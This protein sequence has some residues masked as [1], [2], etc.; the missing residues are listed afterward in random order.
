[1]KKILVAT[2]LLASLA[3]AQRNRRDWLDWRVTDQETVQRSYSV[4][5]ASN[6]GASAKLAVDNVSGFVHVT[7]YSGT[8]VQ[9]SVHK[10]IGAD[11]SSAMEDAKREV[12]LDMSQQGDSVR[13]YVDGPFR[14]H[15]G[16]NYRGDGYYGYRV[17]YDFEIQVPTATELNLKTINYG[18]IV[19]K[20]TQGDFTIGGLNG[21]IE[22]EDVAGAG[23]V[24]TLNGPV[25]VT[26]TRNPTKDTEFRTLNGGID[27]HFQ[28]GLDADL[29]FHRLNGAIYAD[30]DITT[31]PS[32]VSTTGGNGRFVYRMDRGSMEARAGKGGPVM[33]FHTLNGT[34]RLYGKGI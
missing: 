34:I 10:Q 28:P 20:K 14:D 23:S 9:V 27:V 4:G 32:K 33:S 25:K 21:G 13:L 6:A 11:S 15:G 22:M 26:F 16:V 3:V 31:R 24:R 7:G 30:F 18:D 2:A 8:Q 29:D 19:V 17:V 5:S 12:K 1:M